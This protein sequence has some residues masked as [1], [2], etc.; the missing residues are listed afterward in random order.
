M[1]NASLT[2]RR[3]LYSNIFQTLAWVQKNLYR[4][5]ERLGMFIVLAVAGQLL[6][7]MQ[8]L[9]ACSILWLPV[10]IVQQKLYLNLFSIA[11]HS[12]DCRQHH[13]KPQHK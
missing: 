1:K 4:S 12:K 10:K 2:K 11:A 9:P 7:P 6:F 13:V 5:F 8:V 3:L